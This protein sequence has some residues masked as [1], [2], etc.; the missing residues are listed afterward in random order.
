MR[1][2]I[3]ASSNLLS[4]VTRALLYLAQRRYCL[5]ELP[6]EGIYIVRGIGIDYH[7][8]GYLLPAAKRLFVILK[9]Q[10]REM[11]AKRAGKLSGKF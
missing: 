6:V 2:P 7:K 4:I 9:A 10:G 1:L 8:D 3:I 11:M 5:V